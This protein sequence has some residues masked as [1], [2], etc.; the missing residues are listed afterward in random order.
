MNRLQ[1]LHAIGEQLRRAAPATVSAARLAE[2]FDVSR[3]TIERDLDALRRAGAPLWGQNGPGGGVGVLDGSRRLVALTESEIAALVITAH[4]AGEAPL[5]GHARRAAETLS[6]SA[7]EETQRS[8]DRV[9]QLVLLADTDRTQRPVRRTVERAVS[10]QRLLNLE[11]RDRHGEMTER[12]VD[13]VGFLGNAA[14]WSLIA[15]CHLR[16]AGRLFRISRI[17]KA[18]LTTQPAAAHDIHT[19]LGDVPFH[20]RRPEV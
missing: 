9:R 11:Y 16:N 18:N 10:E 17:S 19:V 4:S 13:P 5:A 8:G 20:L 2:E 6:A 1:R 15:H 14:T 12:T 3:R 7:S